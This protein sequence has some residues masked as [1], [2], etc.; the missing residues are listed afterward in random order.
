TGGTRPHRRRSVSP[1]CSA[2][3]RHRRWGVW[4]SHGGRVVHALS[5]SPTEALRERIS[6]RGT[7]RAVGVGLK[8]LVGWRVTSDSGTGPLWRHG[9]RA[10]PARLA[11]AFGRHGGLFPDGDGATPRHAQ[12]ARQRQGPLAGH[13]VGGAFPPLVWACDDALAATQPLRRLPPEK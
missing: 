3:G 9:G 10:S 1:S 6:L 13:A 12:P 4:H 7:C 2:R 8:R 5:C 11:V